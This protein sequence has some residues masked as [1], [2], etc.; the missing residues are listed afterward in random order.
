MMLVLGHVV[1]AW[2]AIRLDQRVTRSSA[3]DLEPGV[4]LALLGTVAASMMTVLS[5]VYSI[6]LVALSLASMQFS[7]RVV[8]GY[9]REPLSQAVAGVFV[10]TFLYCLVVMLQVRSDAPAT[11]V[12]AVGIALLLTVACLALLLIFIQHITR[13]I[14]ANTLVQ[15][16]AHETRA[17]VRAVFVPAAGG[18]RKALVPAPGGTIIRARRSGYIQLLDLDALRFNA[19][20]RRVRLL[21][22]MGTFVPQGGS[23]FET[24]G[25]LS[26]DDADALLDAVDLGEERTLQDDAEYGFRQ[27]VDVALKAIS[28][29]VNDPS[30]AATCIDHL[31]AL[32]IFA[33][34]REDP[35]NVFKAADGGTL[36]M[37][38]TSF[39]DLIDLSVEQIRQY[40]KNDMAVCLRLLRMLT[41]VREAVDAARGAQAIDK[42]IEFI[43]RAARRNF[44]EDDCEELERRVAR[45]QGVVARAGGDMTA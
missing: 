15:R 39:E 32:L 9:V 31:S 5:V 21:R 14:R 44:S 25:E 37:P 4:A 22:T 42:Q 38:R 17:V 28:P 1:L 35:P 10:G 7:T 8:S 13:G 34:V 3:P 40:G 12:I 24:W 30:T 18:A 26:S 41:D 16:I 20:G 36:E 11:P 6:L 2:L 19:R 23:L 43:V 33:G 29:A 27:I 45:F